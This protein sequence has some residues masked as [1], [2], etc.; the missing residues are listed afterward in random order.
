MNKTKSAKNVRV[1]EKIVY[2]D[3]PSKPKKYYDGKPR[4]FESLGKTLGGYFGDTGSTVGKYLGKAVGKITGLGDYKISK[5]VLLHSNQVPFMQNTQ[6]SVVIRNREYL[7][8]IKGSVNFNAINY[9]VNAGLSDV[10]PWLSNVAECFEAYQFE[11]L[12][13]EFKATAGNAISS[14]NNA[15]GSVIM[16]ADYNALDNNYTSKNEA[17]NSMFSVSTKPS[18][19]CIL[20]I[21]CDP[22][23]NNQPRYFVRDGPRT[24]GDL[25]LYDLCKIQ[26]ATQ[27]MQANDINIGELWVSYQVRLFKPNI[28]MITNSNQS[29]HYETISYTGN[30]YFNS[31][32]VKKYDNINITLSNGNRINFANSSVGKVYNVL[33]YMFNITNSFSLI[34]SNFTLVN[35]SLYNALNN[36]TSSNI[37]LPGVP[38]SGG[39][40]IISQGN[41]IFVK[42]DSPGAY[43]QLTGNQSS[44]D[45]YEL[46]INEYYI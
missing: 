44:G 5:N 33:V 39:A 18:D 38:T 16:S 43:I 45:R 6:N 37:D 14:T 12:I 8:D 3:K 11:G 46:L 22:K 9:N 1:V 23:V 28:Q 2:K 10:F 40:G 32:T 30:N 19:N 36:N 24:T 7:I 25:R 26:I 27:G 20:A 29:C 15:L 17:L 13:F 4:V 21:E 34:D 41:N 42:I 31:Q 35:C